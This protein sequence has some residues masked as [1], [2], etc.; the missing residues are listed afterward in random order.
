MDTIESPGVAPVIVAAPA[1]V[2]VHPPDEVIVD[3]AFEVAVVL[4]MA[5]TLVTEIFTVEPIRSLVKQIELLVAPEIL[6]VTPLV[7]L[8][9]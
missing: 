7:V 1:V 5:F 8:T 4:P 9:H 3:V 2:P 6:E